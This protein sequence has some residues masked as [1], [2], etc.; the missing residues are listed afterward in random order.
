MEDQ[1]LRRH[2]ALQDLS[3]HHHHALVA[4]Q[5][6]LKCDP[7]AA[8]SAVEHLRGFWSTA[9]NEHFREEE[10]L[11]LPAYE[12]Y[13]DIDDPDIV[14][15]LT[16]HVRIRSLVSRAL[17][18]GL[19]TAEL[20]ALGERITRHVRHEER[21]VFPKIQSALPE[22]ALN[23]LAPLFSEWIPQP[24]C[25]LPEDRVPQRRPAE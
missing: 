9:G 2:P 5:K 18:G 22:S 3:R 25:R 20:Q 6:L 16:D 10:Q 8:A 1:P 15:V 11:L 13:G 4:A 17:R 19:T 7:S 23:E 24:A 21:V 14:R 12:P